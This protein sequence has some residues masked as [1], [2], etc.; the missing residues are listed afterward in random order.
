MLK[1][2]SSL[3]ILILISTTAYSQKILTNFGEERQK[4]IRDSL[5]EVDARPYNPS[6]W[7]I[8]AAFNVNM[9][10]PDFHKLPEVP[11][12]CPT[13][14][15]GSGS[16][17]SIGGLFQMPLSDRLLLQFRLGWS[18]F[19][20]TLEGDEGKYFP[21]NDNTGLIPGIIRHTIDASL[22][23]IALEPN[24]GYRLFKDLYISAGLNIGFLV[25]KSFEQREE[26]ISP[27]DGVTYADGTKSYLDNDGDI[28]NAPSLLLGI[29][30]R[31][32][33]ELPLNRNRTMFLVP[34]L[35]Y[36]LGL[37][38][39][40]DTASEKWTVNTFKAGLSFKF[41]PVKPEEPAIRDYKFV[42]R[43]D[44]VV[45]PSLLVKAPEIVKGKEKSVFD[46]TSIF[47][48]YFNRELLTVV[49]T[50]Y[51]TDT[52]LVPKKPEITADINITGIDEKGNPVKAD[53]FKVEEF[54]TDTKNFPLLNYVFFDE[55]DS[56]LPG[57]YKKRDKASA[58]RFNPKDLDIYETLPIYYELL[59]II[60][61]RMNSNPGAKLTLTALNSSVGTTKENEG[62]PMKRAVTIRD[63]LQ[64]VWSVDP[65]RMEIKIRDEKLK[66]NS[67]VE[68]IEENRRVEITSDEPAILQ[69]LFKLSD[70]SRTVSPSICRFLPEVKTETPVSKWTIVAK[71]GKTVL[72]EFSGN[73]EVPS[74]VDWNINQEKKTTPRDNT[75]VAYALEVTDS[76]GTTAHSKPKSINVDYLTIRDKT[77]EQTEFKTVERY[78]LILFDLDKSDIRG[79]NKSIVDFLKQRI[80][81]DSYVKITGYTDLLGNAEYNRKLSDARAKSTATA[82]AVTPNELKGVGG[83]Q[84]LYDNSIPEGRFYCRT[85]EVVIT[86][87]V[88]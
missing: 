76:K 56:K 79:T 14:E 40:V 63:Y 8:F 43:T 33:Y 83:S 38:S 67:G 86:T 4:A 37:T 31:I 10:N 20:G 87:P 16:G 49:E 9:H 51:R 55:N 53:K 77:S 81:P 27:S 71:Q 64:E 74:N 84:L 28:P 68:K 48:D 5:L 13:Y 36:H 54:V 30:G 22:S 39:L 32:A 41:A 59:N 50:K 88:K 42:P 6:K 52:I 34:E 11:N 25:G 73:N 57:R 61:S 44:T 17:F 15:K 35:S 65:S 2:T 47:S 58:S 82:M 46:S 24:I 75:P 70:T 3:I 29:T 12:C 69:P 78:N 21:N 19:G 60:G 45:Q 23:E 26:I 85:V 1:W 18:D 62:V 80:K 66:P 72:K 7:G